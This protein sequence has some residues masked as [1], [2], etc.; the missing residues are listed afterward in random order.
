MYSAKK[1]IKPK[2]LYHATFPPF[3]FSSHAPDEDKTG[4]RAP[5]KLVFRAQAHSSITSL[6]LLSPF[7]EQKLVSSHQQ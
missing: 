6:T 3:Y 5:N 2:K 4:I 1:C 7:W